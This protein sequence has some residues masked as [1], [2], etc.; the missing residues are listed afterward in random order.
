MRPSGNTTSRAGDRY[1]TTCTASTRGSRTSRTNR[2]V[3]GTRRTRRDS[4]AV[5]RRTG[6]EDDRT[7]SA[8]TLT[9][10]TSDV[11]LTANCV[12][13]TGTSRATLDGGR[14]TSTGDTADTT[15]HDNRA[16]CAGRETVT[17]GNVHRTASRGRSRGGFTNKVDTGIRVSANS[18][19]HGITAG[20]RVADEDV[21]DR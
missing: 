1:R 13:R 9:C 14:A 11:R 16:T 17:C 12:G 4:R 20:S 2:E 10:A 6:S 3:D 7:T 15:S 5:L 21:V 19:D 18:A 8:G